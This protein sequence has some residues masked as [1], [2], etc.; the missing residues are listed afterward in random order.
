MSRLPARPNL[1]HLR[2]QA[3][4]LL[5]AL[6]EGDPDAAA[7]FAQHLPAAAQLSPAAIRSAGFRLADA[8]SAVARKTG[9]AAWPQLARHVATLRALE[10]TWSFEQLNVEGQPLPAAALA[11][12]RLLIDGDRFR[13]ESPEANYEGVF[14]V[15]VEAQP[16][17]IDIEFVAGPEAG[18][19]NRG[20]FRLDGDRLEICLDMRGQPR[21]RA[22]AAAAGSGHAHEVLRRASS[23]RP[24]A[25]DGGSAAAAAP[26]ASPVPS[27]SSRDGASACGA[28]LARLQGEWSAERVIRDGQELPAAMLRSGRRSA[29][30]DE[31]EIA[32]GGHV[33]LRARVGLDESTQPMRI[34][35]SVL[36]GPAKG[37][38]QQGIFEWR[39]AS[40]CFCMGAPGAAR[41]DDFSAPAGSGRTLSQWRQHS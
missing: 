4:A 32:F 1:D 5:G 12:S 36:A 33:M 15:D 41:P 28:T 24:H 31:V 14:V 7:T 34:D 40:A 21:P 2:R 16:H 39:G 27:A 22:F 29:R 8:Q 23:T 17:G 37:A 3:K 25:V 9:F 30:G 20:I 35:Y 6:A 10:G 38:V 18:N 19:V 11:H 26:S 13:T